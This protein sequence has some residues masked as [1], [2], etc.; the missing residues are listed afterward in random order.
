MPLDV[1]LHQRRADLEVAAAECVEAAM[2]ESDVLLGCRRPEDGS[3]SKVGAPAR[4]IPYGARRSSRAE[5][6]PSKT[7]R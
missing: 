2:D 7:R 6:G 5:A 4:T 1:R 3:A